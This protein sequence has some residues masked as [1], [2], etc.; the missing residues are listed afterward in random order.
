MN[1]EF[2]KWTQRIFDEKSWRKLSKKLKSNLNESLDKHR[3]GIV[4][5]I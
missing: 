5:M 4:Y 3:I 1:M 2:F